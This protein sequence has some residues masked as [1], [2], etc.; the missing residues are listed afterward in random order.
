[1]M[2]MMMMV[3]ATIFYSDTECG[4]QWA[5]CALMMDAHLWTSKNSYARIII[6]TLP[7][8]YGA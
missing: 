6:M 2:M 3:A 1:M 5:A 7:V 8:L 4:L